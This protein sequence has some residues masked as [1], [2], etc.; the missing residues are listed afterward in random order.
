MS[1]SNQKP[2]G[3]SFLGC[4][5]AF[6]RTFWG[7]LPFAFICAAAVA[8]VYLVTREKAVESARVWRAVVVETNGMETTLGGSRR[9]EFWTPS[10]KTKDYL[11]RDGSAI[12][13][14]DKWQMLASDDAVIKFGNMLHS[15]QD[16]LGFRRVEEWGRG[17]TDFKPGWWWSVNVLT[18]CSVGDVNRIYQQFWKPTAPIFI[19]VIDNRER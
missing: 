16:I 8:I 11:A 10:V 5:C 19:E 17:R 4:S 2:E 3:V 15:N 13:P 1:D 9:M 7:T 12:R 14:K 18:N 6:P